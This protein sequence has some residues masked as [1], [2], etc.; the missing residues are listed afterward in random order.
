MRRVL[1]LRIVEGQSTEEYVDADMV[2]HRTVVAAA[3]NNVLLELFDGF[4]P[5]VRQAMID[6]LVLQSAGTPC[7]LDASGDDQEAHAELVQA[8]TDREPATAAQLSRTH[9][10]ALKVALA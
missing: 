8:I 10:T 1:A 6:M 2:L 5:R 4:V 7:D 9:L 3:H